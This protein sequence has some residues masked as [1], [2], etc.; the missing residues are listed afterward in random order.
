MLKACSSHWVVPLICFLKAGILLSKNRIF[1]FKAFYV[2]IKFH[3]KK[4]GIM[5]KLN[6]VIILVAVTLFLFS[7]VTPCSAE[8]ITILGNSKKPPKTYLKSGAPEGILIEIMRYMDDHLPQSSFLS[9]PYHSVLTSQ[10]GCIK[11]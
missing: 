4:R 10:N 7:F 6:Q 2:M 9:G 3:F 11:D 8:Q 1:K 5:T